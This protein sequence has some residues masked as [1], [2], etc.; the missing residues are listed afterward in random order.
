MKEWAAVDVPSA[1]GE[2]DAWRQL[3]ADARTYVG[4]LA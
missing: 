2:P 1:L 4:G 3:M